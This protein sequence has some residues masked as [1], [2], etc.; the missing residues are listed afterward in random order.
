M[1]VWQVG[2]LVLLIALAPCGLVLLR[3]SV[4]DALVALELVATLAAAIL[5]LLSESYHRSTYF[6]VPVVLA[7]LNFVGGLVFVRFFADRRL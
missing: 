1:N 6:A 7:F 5:V 3:G 4:L 2:A